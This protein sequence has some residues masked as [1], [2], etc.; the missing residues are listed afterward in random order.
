M[1]PAGVIPNPKRTASSK[2]ASYHPDTD[3]QISASRWAVPLRATSTRR[4]RGPPGVD[5]RLKTLGFATSKHTF[6]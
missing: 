4:K 1:D 6:A 2:R 5:M 3:A